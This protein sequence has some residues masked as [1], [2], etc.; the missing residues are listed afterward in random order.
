MKHWMAKD[1]VEVWACQNMIRFIRDFDD[2]SFVLYEEHFVPC[3]VHATITA[4]S[5]TTRKCVSWCENSNPEQ[6][7]EEPLCYSICIVEWKD[8]RKFKF[9]Q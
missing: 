5:I 3:W 8:F 6:S 7:E 2:S 4:M 9:S 1:G